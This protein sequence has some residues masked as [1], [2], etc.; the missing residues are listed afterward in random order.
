MIDSLT[1]EFII[2]VGETDSESDTSED[3]EM[4]SDD[5]NPCSSTSTYNYIDGVQPLQ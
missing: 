1:E 2:H 4:D 3:S 5:E